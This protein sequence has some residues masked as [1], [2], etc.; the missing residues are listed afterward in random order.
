M[1]VYLPIAR[2]LS[3]LDDVNMLKVWNPYVQMIAAFCTASIFIN[4]HVTRYICQKNTNILNTSAA[5]LW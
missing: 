1:L 2:V 5:T 3:L 4:E